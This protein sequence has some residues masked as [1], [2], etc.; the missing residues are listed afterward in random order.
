MIRLLVRLVLLLLAAAV[1]VAAL[2]V[3]AARGAPPSLTILQPSR[4]V[5]RTGTLEL[6]AGAPGALLTVLTVTLEQ[7]GRSVP[8][9]SL[10][11][12]QSAEIA[13]A[14]PDH[15]RVTR[16]IG[17]DRVPE[18]ES[19]PATI[20]VEASRRSFLGLRTLSSRVTKEFQVRLEPP[21]LAVVSTHHYVNHGGAEAVVYRASPSDVASGVR[22]GEVE[23]P[24]YPAADAGV[25]GADP[26]LKVAF[27][28]LLHD[29]DLATPIALFARDEAGNEST[30]AFVDGVF[31]K[32]F[33]RS[34]IALDDLFLARVVP[35]ILAHAPDL[36][37]KVGG[38]DLLPAFL[39]INNDLREANAEQIEQVASDTSKSRL[40]DG[41]FIQ[42]DNSKVEASFADHRTYLYAG[43]EIDQQV[44]LGFDLAVTA[45]VPIVA[46]NAGR[47]TH[48]GWLGIYGNSVIL[49][50]GLGVASLYAHL[51][52]LDVARGDRVAR[53]QAI[54][55]SG[56]TGLAGGDHL[57]FTMLVGGRPVNPVEWW[58][59]RWIEDRV[60]R[61]LRAA[62]EPAPGR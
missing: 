13:Q 36:K 46:A 62:A 22:V 15:L 23:Y 52:S 41:G 61:K 43:R 51:S 1:A 47:V 32:P 12:P 25:S 2:W 26:E 42:L 54:G 34:R 24:G 56:M 19:G 39:A 3:W 35:E 14:D 28:A 40:W 30:A 21:R 38:P 59:P 45:A 20:V 27:F 10:D 5:G 58:D 6:T 29:Q 50:H 7:N 44:H 17:K 18:L 55:R 53:G 11:S 31:P 37:E 48:A 8:L 16:P 33:R 4:A 9:F 49:D 57:H 60:E